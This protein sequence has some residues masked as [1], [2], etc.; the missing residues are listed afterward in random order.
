MYITCD[1][2]RPPYEEPQKIIRFACRPKDI[3][4]L[5]ELKSAVLM[6]VIVWHLLWTAASVRRDSVFLLI[7]NCVLNYGYFSNSQCTVKLIIGRYYILKER[8]PTVLSIYIHNYIHLKFEL[9]MCFLT[10]SIF[11]F[12]SVFFQNIALLGKLFTDCLAIISYNSFHIIIYN[13]VGKQHKCKNNLVQK[14]ICFRIR[15]PWNFKI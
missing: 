12:Y 2:L 7:N 10:C 13:I 8:V 1:E 9:G 4:V 15:V 6:T 3:V 14:K 11:D 5:V